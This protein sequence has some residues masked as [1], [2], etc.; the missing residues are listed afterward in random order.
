[1][2]I[3]RAALFFKQFNFLQGV[4]FLLSE[5]CRKVLDRYS[6]SS[7]SQTGEDRIIQA[8]LGNEPGFFID[9][10]CNH[11]QLCSNTFS[12]YNRGWKGIN[13]DA[14][15]NLIDQ[16]KNLRLVDISVCAAIS[17]KEQEVVF[18]E[19]VDPFVSSISQSHVEE[20]RRHRAIKGTKIIK[21]VT[22]TAVLTEFKAPSRPDLLCIDVEGHD[23]EVLT[24]LDLKRYR[25]RLI[26]I[27]M[28]GFELNNPNENKIF[29]SL[30]SS[31]YKMIGFVIMNGYFI[32]IQKTDTE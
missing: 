12:L 29:V 13:I 10:G 5:I 11:P 26:V 19:F 9:V 24:S 6:I 1:M 23:Y 32:D 21:T 18:T 3:S 28:H 4:R 7:Y 8:I 15:A 20:W 22:L 17:D 30:I 27:E 25:P 31:G 16:Q 14:N 2:K